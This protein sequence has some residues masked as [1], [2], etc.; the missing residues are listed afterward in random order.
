MRNALTI[1]HRYCGLAS[2]IFLALAGLTGSILVLRGP[3]DRALNP[4]LLIAGAA[5]NGEVLSSTVP[6][7]T[8]F[9]HRSPDLQ[10]VAFPAHISAGETIELQVSGK[11]GHPAPERNLIYLDPSSG[12]VVGSRSSQGGWGRHGFVSGLAQFHFNLLAGDAGRYFMGVIAIL[13]VLSS[14]AGIVMTFPER[15][16]FWKN[17]WRN[18]RF[19]RSSPLPRLLLDLHRSTALWLLPA[20][21]V[22]ALTSVALNFWGEAYAPAVTKISPLQYDLFEQDAPYPDGAVPQLQYSDALAAAENHAAS[23]GLKWQPARMM[24]LPDWNLYGVKFS[25]GGYLNYEMLGPVDYYFDG[26]SGEFRHQVDPY[27]DSAG[28]AMIRMVYPLHSGEMFG[29]ISLVI[30]FLAG[31]ATLLQSATGCYIWLKKR[32][33]RLAQRS[34]AQRQGTAA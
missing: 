18:W 32:K 30:I 27:S 20:I 19:R 4:D 25:E 16:P 24:Y 9:E 3:L 17:W 2:M 8:E 11:P 34:A 1:I 10:I 12:D 13:W 21:L 14:L 33:S 5:A 28:L 22:L 26:N 15:Q 31:L 23:T 29:T 7:V 6:M